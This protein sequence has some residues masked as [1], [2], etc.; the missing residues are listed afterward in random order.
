MHP[1]LQSGTVH[2]W[3]VDLDVVPAESITCLSDEERER[4]LERRD[5]PELAHKRRRRAAAR[6]ALRELLGTY[7]ELAPGEVALATLPSGKVVLSHELRV[8]AQLEFSVSHSGGVGMFAVA[9]GAAVGVD[10]EVNRGA[11][12]KAEG[13]PYSP[14]SSRTSR[15]MAGFLRRWTMRESA[16]KCGYLRPTVAG[17]PTP[18]CPWITELPLNGI[19]AALAASSRPSA[20]ACLTH[21]R[22]SG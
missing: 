5:F 19:A 12:M 16:L 10:V 2:V 21:V 11:R 18:P 7:L 20:V 6:A 14:R 1:R 15:Q 3:L 17:M 22:H 8:L 13:R 4:W 9:R